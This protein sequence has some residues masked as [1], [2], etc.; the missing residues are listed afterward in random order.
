MVSQP[1]LSEL[2]IILKEDYNVSLPPEE[3][4]GVANA[5]VGMFELLA[6]MDVNRGINENYVNSN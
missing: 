4:M 1:L 3:L 6:K 5:L 2:K